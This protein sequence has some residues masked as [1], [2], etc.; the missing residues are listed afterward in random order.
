VVGNL[1]AGDLLKRT[2]RL[3]G[4]AHQFRGIPVDLVEIGA[5]RR[6]PGIARSA[7]DGSVETS[8]GAI[9]RHLWACWIPGDA[10]PGAVNPVAAD[11]AVTEVRREHESVIRRDGEPA[12]LR[13]QAWARVD[14]HERADVDLAV[15]VNGCHGAPIAD[16]ISED[17][18]IRP[19]VQ[20]GDVER[21]ARLRVVEP[22]CAKRAVILQGEYDEAVGIW[23][24]RSDHLEFAVWLLDPENR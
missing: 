4:V 7:G 21:R 12:Q 19:A 1:H 23:R 8:G 2:V 11:V 9:A 5:I 22:G 10:E 6:N 3:S 15:S 24:I 17:K 18:G 13:R 14:L 16:G 20:E